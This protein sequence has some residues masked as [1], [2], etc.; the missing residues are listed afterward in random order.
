MLKHLVKITQFSIHFSNVLFTRKRPC[1]VLQQDSEIAK[2]N[3]SRLMIR[4]DGAIYCLEHIA[5]DESLQ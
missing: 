5:L 4:N 1:I 2:G 3:D